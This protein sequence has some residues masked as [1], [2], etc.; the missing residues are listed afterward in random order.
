MTKQTLQL[1]LEP[2]RVLDLTEGGNM[3]GARFLGDMGADVIKIER[4]DGSPSR[5]GPYYK[6]IC[7][8]EKSLFWFAYNVNKRGI[9]LDITCEEGRELLIKLVQTADIVMESFQPGY[10]QSLE[11]GYED[12]CKIKPDIIMAS[13]SPFGQTG[14]KAHYKGSELTNWASGCYLYICGDPDR[15]PNWIS[16]PQASLHA[17]AEAS[18]G[19]MMALWHRNLTGEGQYVDVSTQECVVA[20]CFNTPEMW[21]LNHVEFTRYSKGINIGGN[22]G[23]KITCVFECKD[24]HLILV[25]QGGVQPFVNSMAALAQW[26]AQEGMA[27]EWYM[28]LDWAEDYNASKLTQ[29]MIDKVESQIIAFL[30]TKTKKE[31]YEEGAL[32]RRILIGPIATAKDVCENAQLEA[33]NFWVELDHPELNDTITYPGPPLNLSET[34]ISYRRRAPLIGEHNSEIYQGELGMTAETLAELEA[35][36]VI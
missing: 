24:G 12:L 27:D 19:A 32:K 2:Y 7:E 20:C 9:T 33:R 34:S 31:L 28:S 11:L 35:K 13:I 17:G 1:A 25:A 21:D 4:P 29:E 6:D 10:L 16:F 26:M 15:P 14:P 18:A 8:P 3:I 36:E 23:V 5:I 22:T 30:K